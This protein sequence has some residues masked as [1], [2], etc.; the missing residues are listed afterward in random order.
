[1]FDK[2]ISF[3]KSRYSQERPVPLHAPRLDGNEKQYLADC[4]DS[5]FVSYVGPFV[6][7]FEKD[8]EAYTGA[9]HAIAVVNGTA[10]L[11]LSL[12]LAGVSPGDEVITQPLTFVATANAISY[13]GAIPVF[14]DIEKSTLGLD[15]EAVSDF[16]KTHAEVRQDG[17]CYNKTSGR[18]IAACVPVHTFGHPCRMDRLMELSATYSI[19]VVEDAAEAMGSLFQGRHL[20]TFGALGILSFNGNKPL[21]T[22]GG[23][24]ILTND[25]ELAHRAKHIS[26]TAKQPHAWEFYHDQTGY[27][28]RIPN[29]NAAVGCAQMERFDTFLKNKRE[30]AAAYA[31][32]FAQL[33]IP[34][35]S[36][37]EQARSN[38]WLNAIILEDRKARD[39]F[40]KYANDHQVQARPVWRLMTR[41]PMFS[42]CQHGPL[43]TAEWIEDRLVNIPSSVTQ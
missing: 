39:A 37:P 19:P 22:G 23:G 12:I 36:E 43:D 5:T 21:T 10:A 20:G 14:A 17:F 34:F 6:G 8:L 31:D 9:G 13:C 4:I 32:F 16:L 38:Y 33:N 15:P 26:T 18:K 30:T 11:H 3:I 28:N 42:Q 1:M 2:I 35:V 27:N 41:L 29:I 7:R 24:A 25:P 40:L